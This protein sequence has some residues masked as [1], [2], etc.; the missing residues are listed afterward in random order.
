MPFK[1]NISKSAISSYLPFSFAIGCKKMNAVE[2]YNSA[3]AAY[4]NNSIFFKHRQTL[5]MRS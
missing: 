2:I 3:G 1:F 4:K 5:T